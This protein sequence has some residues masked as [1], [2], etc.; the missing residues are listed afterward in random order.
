MRQR[1]VVAAASGMLLWLSASCAPSYEVRTLASPD[2]RITS[3]RS[4]RVLP[5][6][7][8][9]DGR[10]GAGGSYDP[11][12]NNSITNR[13]LRETISRAL[14]ARGYVADEQ[15]P[16]FAVAV[17]A[18]AYEEL[19]VTVW[20]Y[21]YPF[22][23]R[24]RDPMW[25]AERVTTFTEGTVVVDVVSPS[26]RELWWRGSG[27]VR[28]DNED[29]AKD[30]RQLRKVAEAIVKRFPAAAAPAVTAAR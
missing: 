14:M 24:W 9:R 12:V 7:S 13:A 29:P 15:R 18:S 2:A 10:E 19:D 8:R 6:P 27:S 20:D 3:L 4:F 17:Y 1:L 30:T 11:M 16:D 22:W 25:P 21:G 5:V 26:S 28:L 23:P